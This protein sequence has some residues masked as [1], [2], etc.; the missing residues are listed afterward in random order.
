MT[1]Q[2]AR[3]IIIKQL[4]DYLKNLDEYEIKNISEEIYPSGL[5]EIWDKI[6]AYIKEN[7]T[8]PAYNDIQFDPIKYRD[9]PEK[10][11]MP[12]KYILEK[13]EDIKTELIDTIDNCFDENDN[14]E[15]ILI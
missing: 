13:I 15:N 10:A 12:V 3:E 4:D 5:N 8:L 1:K 2:N 6:E 9:P 7:G 14:S 11:D